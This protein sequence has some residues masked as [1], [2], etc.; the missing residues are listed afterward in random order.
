M[1]QCQVLYKDHGCTSLGESPDT[2]FSESAL[3]VE[4]FAGLGWMQIIYK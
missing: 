3:A 2:T 1:C 4:G